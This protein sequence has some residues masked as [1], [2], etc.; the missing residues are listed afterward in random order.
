MWISGLPV[1][2]RWTKPAR[3]GDSKTAPNLEVEALPVA[4]RHGFIWIWHDSERATGETPWFNELSDRSWSYSQQSTEWP[5]HVTRCI[6]NQLDYAH[7]PLFP[8]QHDRT[9]K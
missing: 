7:L 9:A 5:I 6:E 3:P 8:S 2:S 4:E 1:R